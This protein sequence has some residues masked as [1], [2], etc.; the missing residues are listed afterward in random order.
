[1]QSDVTCAISGTL[2]VLGGWVSVMWGKL[3]SYWQNRNNAKQPTVF[4]RSVSL[5]LQICWEVI[6]G[7]RFFYGALLVGWGIPA[8]FIAIALPVTGVSY[9]FGTTCHINHDRGLQDFWGPLLGLAGATTVFQF[10]TFGY[11]IKVYIK[12]LLRDDSTQNSSQLPSYHGSIRTVTPKAAY[13]RVRKVIALQWRGIAIVLI[14]IADVV[15][16]SVIFVALDN[17][18]QAETQDVAKVQP[19]LS[20]LLLSGGNKNAC[21]DKASGLVINEATVLAV[22]ILLSVSRFT[23]YTPGT[24]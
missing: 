24:N 3:L 2:I 6:P 17:K 23:M 15:F 22:L 4:L 10:V 5:H 12:S 1:M 8:L 14:I 11:C 13:R 21:L 20:C 16:F 19:W 9:R 7:R 18:T